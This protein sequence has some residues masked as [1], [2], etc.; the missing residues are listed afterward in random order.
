[1]SLNRVRTRSLPVGVMV[2]TSTGRSGRRSCTAWMIGAAAFVSPA[3]T[4]WNHTAPA[5]SGG[6]LPNR[7]PMRSP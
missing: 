6:A 5:G 3:E 2:V 4:V 1:M 7:S